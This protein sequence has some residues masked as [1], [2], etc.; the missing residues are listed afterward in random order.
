[1]NPKDFR[2]GER[3]PSFQDPDLPYD[4]NVEP[5]RKGQF[6]ANCN[7]F[8]IVPDPILGEKT[9]C[10][11]EPPAA[12]FLGINQTATVNPATGKPMQYPVVA[13]FQRPTEPEK[14]CRKWEWVGPQKE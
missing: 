9:V 2:F 13:G 6:C 10:C 4:P 12:I 5:P 11:A 14:W 3:E 7:A 1:M 8:V